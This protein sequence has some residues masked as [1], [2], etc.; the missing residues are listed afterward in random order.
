MLVSFKLKFSK[1]S[2]R[3]ATIVKSSLKRIIIEV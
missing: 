1:F 2:V 3:D